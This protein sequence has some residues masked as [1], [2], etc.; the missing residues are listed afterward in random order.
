[1]RLRRWNP[2]YAYAGIYSP[3]ISIVDTHSLMKYFE[4]KAKG[5]GVT[6]AYGCEVVGTEKM[7]SI[8]RVSIKDAD[9]KLYDFSTGILI[10]SAGLDSDKISR[11]LGIDKYKLY[12]C[13]GEYL[14]MNGAAKNYIHRLIY[15][16]PTQNSLGIHTL[17]DMQAQS[18]LG[19]NAFYVDKIDYSVDSSN[20][21]KTCSS[22]NKYLLFLK[23]GDLTPNMAAIRAKLQGP[24]EDVKDFVISCGEEKDLACFINLIGIDSPGLTSA[25]AIARYVLSSACFQD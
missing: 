1:M 19:P 3:F 2:I 24:D 6:F 12:Y 21:K 25:P 9:G 4:Q 13:K 20:V 8:Y 14:A 15:P 7:K 5:N 11:M 17:V 18:K 23:P 16:L 22:V 10:N